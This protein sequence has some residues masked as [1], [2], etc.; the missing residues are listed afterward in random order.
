MHKKHYDPSDH[1][2]GTDTMHGHGGQ[3]YKR[4]S[5]LDSKATSL[6]ERRETA[7]L[8]YDKKGE[9]KRVL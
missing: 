1:H 8:F 5:N 3:L 9:F 2:R 6:T 4:D 7:A